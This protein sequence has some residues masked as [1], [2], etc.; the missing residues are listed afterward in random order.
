[1]T[2]IRT[3][4]NREAAIEFFRRQKLPFEFRIESLTEDTRTSRQN[5]YLFAA[6][7]PPIC[8][9]TG[10]TKEEV[11]EWVCGTHF[12][13][14]DRKVPKTPH[15][16]NGIESV[17]VRTTTRDEFGK[18]DT[19]SKEVFAGFLEE[20][21]RLASKVNVLIVERWEGE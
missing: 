19:V 9:A 20:V 2:I 16:P 11:H 12:G 18:R 1:M 14:T 13:W 10:Y 17:P 7:Y 8:E 5:R 3:E 4:Q 21:Y 15:N 6:C